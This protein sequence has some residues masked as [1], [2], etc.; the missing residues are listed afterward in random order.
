MAAQQLNEADHRPRR[1]S[2]G[3]TW[4][5]NLLVVYTCLSRWRLI[6][7]VG[8]HGSSEILLWEDITAHLARE[9]I[10]TGDGKYRLQRSSGSSPEAAMQQP[11]RRGA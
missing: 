10:T 2:M 6:S 1:C 4:R 8:R 3:R 7:D 11:P 5:S 9:S